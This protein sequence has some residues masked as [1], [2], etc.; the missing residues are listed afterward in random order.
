MKGRQ[1][2]GAS[3][4]TKIVHASHNTLKSI[5]PSSWDDIILNFIH[6]I[7]YYA[8]N[9]ENMASVQLLQVGRRRRLAVQ[10]ISAP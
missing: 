5:A 10:E 6:N 7:Y 1:Q 8:T 3:Q 2:H 4:Q 9:Q